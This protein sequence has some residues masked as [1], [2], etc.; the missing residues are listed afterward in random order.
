MTAQ[1]PR[2]PLEIIELIADYS[3]TIGLSFVLNLSATCRYFAAYIKKPAVAVEAVKTIQALLLPASVARHLPPTAP[4]AFAEWLAFLRQQL[5][6]QDVFGRLTFTGERRS[7]SLVDLHIPRPPVRNS[8]GEWIPCPSY[9]LLSRTAITHFLPISVRDGRF[10]PTR[11]S[12]TEKLEWVEREQASSGCIRN[13][14]HRLE[15]SDAGALYV[16]MK[17]G[18]QPKVSSADV[19]WLVVN[20]DIPFDR[21]ICSATHSVASKVVEQDFRN[22]Q[23][24]TFSGKILCG[25][26]GNDDY[27]YMVDPAVA[28]LSGYFVIVYLSQDLIQQSDLFFFKRDGRLILSL[29]RTLEAEVN[30]ECLE[31]LKSRMIKR[32]PEELEELPENIKLVDLD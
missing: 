23:I 17:L 25:A 32:R 29:G 21:S 28:S 10:E 31:L 30:S 13:S 9:G 15:R 20:C 26:R 2:I 8:E 4:M 12:R 18:G 22:P 7:P 27:L 5:T 16:P 24:E 14:R 1:S 3:L 19:R 6:L 11:Y